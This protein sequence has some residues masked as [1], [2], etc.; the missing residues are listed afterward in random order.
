ML[1]NILAWALAMLDDML[2]QTMSVVDDR[3]SQLTAIQKRN[4]AAAHIRNIYASLAGSP[5]AAFYDSDDLWAQSMLLVNDPDFEDA[6]RVLHANGYQVTS[7][8]CY[9]PT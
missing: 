3:P 1:D 7:G 9:R 2:K 6:Y 5:A 4:W 8:Y